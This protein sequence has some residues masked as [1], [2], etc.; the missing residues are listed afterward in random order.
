[1]I[2]SCRTCKH[3]TH[4]GTFQVKLICKNALALKTLND[5]TS[6]IEVCSEASTSRRFN[7]EQ[8]AKCIQRVAQCGQYQSDLT[9]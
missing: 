3:S 1:M 6:T 4:A 8:D 5:G 7:V 9:V 2:A